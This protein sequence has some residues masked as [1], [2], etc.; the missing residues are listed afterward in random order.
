VPVSKSD[1]L[2]KMRIT[3]KNFICCS[4]FGID[5]SV[6]VLVLYSL[7]KSQKQTVTSAMDNLKKAQLQPET[8]KWLHQFSL[9]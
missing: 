3:V 7:S 4:L 5:F 6:D 8:G 1:I 9:A 2:N